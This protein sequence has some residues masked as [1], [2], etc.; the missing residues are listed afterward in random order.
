MAKSREGWQWTPDTS[1]QAGLPSIGV[2]EPSQNIHNPK[3]IFDVIVVGA[4]YTGLTAARDTSTTGSSSAGKPIAYVVSLLTSIIG[5][6][7]LLLEGRDRIGGRTW[8]SNIDGYPFEMGGTWVHW[9]QPHVYR[10]LSRYGMKDELVHSTDFTYKHNYF[11]FLTEAG[12]RS[13]SHEEEVMI[14]SPFCS[15]GLLANGV[16][17]HCSP[18][19]LKNSSM[20]TEISGER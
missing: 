9:F 4:G 20:S 10:E 7:T 12:R 5:L 11:S 16:R 19:R 1:L 14:P 6:K 2:I 3:E 15:P 8:S 17:M 18:V 13:M